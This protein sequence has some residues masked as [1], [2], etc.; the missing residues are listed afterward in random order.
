VVSGCGIAILYVSTYAAFNFYHLIDQPPAFALMSGVTM[1]AAWLSDRQRSQ[2]LALAAVGGGFATPFLLRGATDAEMALFGYESIL[3]AGTTFL[4]RRRDW[5]TLNVASYVFTVLT[6]GAWAARFYTASKYLPT[7][8]FLT[9]FCA[10]FLYILRESRHSRHA[11]AEAERAILWTAPC[12]YYFASLAILSPH[13]AAFLVYLVILSLVGT[14]I[15]SRAGS[16]VRLAFWLVV[17]VPLLLW[18]D[19]HGGRPWLVA[20]LAAWAGVY[21]LNL[22]GLVEATLGGDPRF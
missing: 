20:G 6:V 4:S 10:M 21:F 2:S 7:E 19:A 15:G 12:L 3:I 1:L 18:S 11:L 16:K 22:A 8:L 13:S 14:L 5:P 9:V 17:A